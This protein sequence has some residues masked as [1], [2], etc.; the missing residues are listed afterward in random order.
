MSGEKNGRGERHVKI[1][2]TVNGRSI[3]FP[4]NIYVWKNQMEGERII[5]HPQAIGLNAMLGK[6][7]IDLQNVEIEH[8]MIMLGVNGKL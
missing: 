8:I 2:A 3:T 4:T 1:M 7:I 5:D 6:Y